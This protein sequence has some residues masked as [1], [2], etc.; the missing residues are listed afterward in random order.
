MFYPIVKGV[1]FASASQKTF[2]FPHL[3]RVSGD[4]T[5]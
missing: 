1:F 3:P 5:V 2:L 4:G